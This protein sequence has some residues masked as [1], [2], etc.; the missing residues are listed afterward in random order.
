M[1]IDLSKLPVWEAIAG[2]LVISLA[3]T[4]FFAFRIDNDDEEANGEPAEETP[5]GT[6]IA[7]GST[8]AM[9]MRD[10]L[11]DPRDLLVAAGAAV[12]FDITNDGAAVHNMHIAGPGGDYGGEGSVVS[13]PETV[14]GGDTATLS[15]TAPAEPGEVDFQCDFHPGQ[16]AGVITVQEAAAAPPGGEPAESPAASPSP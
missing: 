9:S 1:K 13:D 12:T 3:V 15:W 8:I 16:M 7:D 10:N 5:A 6:P 2:F 4:F 11:F 14:N